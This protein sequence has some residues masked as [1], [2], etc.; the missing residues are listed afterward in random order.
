MVPDPIPVKY[1]VPNPLVADVIPT[2]VPVE[3]TPTFTV[4]IPI[5]SSEIFATYKVDWFERVTEV[6]IPFVETPRTPPSF[7]EYVSWSPVSSLCFGI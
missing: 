3:P 5:K 4:D 2:N 7:G 6:E 1:K